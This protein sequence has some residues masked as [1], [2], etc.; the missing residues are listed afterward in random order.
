MP[1]TQ[2]PPTASPAFTSAAGLIKPNVLQA[3]DILLSCGTEALS[4]L[5][6]RL[7]G[8]DYSHSA[9]YDGEYA[10]DATSKGVVRRDLKQDMD[11]QWYVDAYRWHSP[12]PGDIDL[13]EPSY[14]YEPVITRNTAIVDAKTQFAYDELL[15]AGLVI[16]V[17]KQPDDE[18]LRTAVRLLLSR[19]QEW[20]HDHITS[21]PPTQS[22]TCA[23]TVAVSFDEAEKS[24]YEIAIEIDKSRDYGVIARARPTTPAAVVTQ[25]FSSY[26]DVRQGYAD[27]IAAASPDMQR[28]LKAAL[29]AGRGMPIKIP[30]GCVTP[31]DLQTSPNLRLIGRLS[32]KPTPPA[33]S[34]PT[35][36]LVLDLIREYGPHKQETLSRQ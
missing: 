30:P 24:K 22:M 11:V 3:G 5:I 20:V 31:R 21:K 15:M 23:E 36:R 33:A 9:V 35:W 2:T 32:E 28:A 19:V 29:D 26:D 6:K 16:A 7:D 17:S 4:M 1:A 25:T 10:V 13:G 14:P 8:G 27:A 12:S 34:E 18:W